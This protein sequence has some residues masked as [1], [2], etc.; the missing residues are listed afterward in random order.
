MFIELLERSAT[1][2]FVAT[3]LIAIILV[4][5]LLVEKKNVV[6]EKVVEIRSYWLELEGRELLRLDLEGD[7]YVSLWYPPQEG[8]YVFIKKG[9]GIAVKEY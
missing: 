3:V 5:L 7:G 6:A 2:R 1:A 8:D 4:A 9:T